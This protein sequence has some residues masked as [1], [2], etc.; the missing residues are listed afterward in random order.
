M[1][2][3]RPRKAKG[4]M[5][6]T[7]IGTFSS[8]P[9]YWSVEDVGEFLQAQGFSDVMEA[10]GDHEV[11]GKSLLLLEERHLMESFN[12][13]L[14]PALKLLDCIEKLSHPN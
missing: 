9:K 6:H 12:M 2:I 10:F 3:R 14:G 13:K 8:P 4:H 5:Y 11:D 7:K 1:R